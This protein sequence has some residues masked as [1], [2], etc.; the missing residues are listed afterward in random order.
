VKR[1]ALAIALAL[2][3]SPRIAGAADPILIESGE[4]TAVYRFL[5]GIARGSYTTLYAFTLVDA[6]QHHD[7]RTFLRFYPR[8]DL[9]G[10]CVESAEVYVFYG[11]EFEG[12]GS[13]GTEP[14]VL[15][16][17][18]VLAPWSAAT[19]TWNNQPPIGDPTG[20][21]ENI[22]AH[23]FL[24]CDV[25]ATVQAWAD[26]APDYGIALSS[27][28][29]RVMGFYSFEATG[30]DPALRPALAI[31][32]ADDPQACPEPAWAAAAA[33]AALLSWKRRHS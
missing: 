15:T 13:G 18:P 29:D 32:L 11:F 23:D 31:T 12:F 25:T 21:V 16:C 6:G 14:G 30:V 4:D 22:T 24:A 1:A 33:V 5:P 17:S 20:M 7:F 9:T 28:T 2:V 19:A 27:P 3:T 26:G 10:A 8:P